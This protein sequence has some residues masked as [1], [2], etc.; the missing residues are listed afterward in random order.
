MKIS[1]RN[2][3]QGK[4]AELKKGAVNSE[5][6]I[7]SGSEKLVAIITN[8]AVESLGIKVDS[9]VVAV[10]KAQSVL[11]AKGEASLSL[12][13]RN[14]IKGIISEIK[15]GAVN[16][17]VIITTPAGVSLVAIITQEACKELGLQK[18]S[19]ACAIIKASNILV[20]AN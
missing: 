2:Q 19:E 18:G 17:E 13:A 8:E 3:I 14:K 15:E 6:I 1:A 5:V 4:V 9:S 20:G 11:V 16:C 12:S 10:F 7:A